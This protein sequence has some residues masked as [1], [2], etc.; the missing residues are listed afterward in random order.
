MPRLPHILPVALL[1]LAN[2][3]AAQQSLADEALAHS[4]DQL[5]ASIGTWDVETSFVSPDGSVGRVV[6]GTYEFSWVVPD[7][8][9]SGRSAIPSLAQAAG[10]LFYIREQ[11]REIEMVSVGT[12]GRLW[13]MTGPLGSEV[14]QTPEYETPDGGTGALR[15][16]RFNVQ[17]DSFESKKEYTSDGGRTWTQGNHQSFRRRSG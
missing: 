6:A 13:V 4:V 12:D 7:R 15:F 10:I 14:R 2:P 1:L 3:L 9:V 5:R 8:V 16:T 17:P 11:T